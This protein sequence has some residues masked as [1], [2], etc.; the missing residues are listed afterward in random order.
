MSGI[1]LFF[2]ELEMTIL[3]SGKEAI[4]WIHSRRIFGPRPGLQRIEALLV[5][6]GNPEKNQ[7]YIHIAGTNGKG[8]TTKFLANLLQSV[9][10]TVGTFTSPFVE[11]FNERIQINNQFI[12]DEELLSLVN[13]ILPFVKKPDQNPELTG[14]TEFEI[15]TVLAFM[16]FKGKTDVAVI[17][18][19]L[20]GLLDS[21]NVITPVLSG[22]T[23]IG[24]D[25]TDVLGDT[26]EKIAF[27][28]G[29]IIKES[30]PVVTG[31]ISKEALTVIQKIAAEK[32][33]T[34]YQYEKDYQVT[35]E[36][37]LENGE[38][39][40]YQFNDWQLK[41][42][43]IP[44]IGRHQ[45]ENASLGLTL[46]FL[47]AKIKHL[48]VVSKEIQKGLQQ[49][50][51]PARMEI[52]NENPLI[53]LDG[54]HNDHAIKRLVENVRVRF[55]GR[56]IW[57][58]YSALKSKDIEEMVEDLNQISH[59]TLILTTFEHPKALT[60]ADLK[61]LKEKGYQTFPL[62]QDG[63]VTITQE[64]DENDV[65]IITGSLYFSSEVRP[66]FEEG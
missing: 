51:W 23:T 21:T 1:L 37:D 52:L 45:V 36:R 59:A 65:L 54:A 40:S 27:Q 2:K 48:Q 10:L 6:L 41:H 8:S 39:F 55:K 42:L 64:M 53:I 60:L 26:L 14:I 4:D 50:S 30:V 13:K 15:N 63:L 31:N 19:G 22:I 38:Q 17:E 58:L 28:K 16:H 47:Y 29:G 33:S 34:H 46:F 66:L 12:S 32:K 24:Y 3:K 18:V 25:H 11:A 56:K 43:K 44:L 49:T 61:Q 35:F 57:I 62:W 5:M 9:G 20:G 7:N